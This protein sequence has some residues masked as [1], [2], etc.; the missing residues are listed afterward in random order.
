MVLSLRRK[1][2]LEKTI[3]EYISRAEPV[4]SSWLEDRYDMACS[5][6]TIRSELLFLTEDGYLE[7]PHVSAGRVP[8]DKGYRFFVDEFLYGDSRESEAEELFS[9]QEIERA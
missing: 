3:F 2:I 6:A 7:Q 1:D 9:R 4:S 8:S 5:P